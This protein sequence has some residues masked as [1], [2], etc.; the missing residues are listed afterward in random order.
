MIGIAIDAILLMILLKTI[1]DEE[2]NVLTAFAL[3]LIASIAT[4][5]LATALAAIMGVAGI[6]V[7]GIVAAALLGVAI[8][9]LFGVEINRSFAIGGIFFLVH[10][11]FGIGVLLLFPK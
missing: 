2:I 9:A 6:I 8:S 5:V 7:A 10:I 3:A 1:S 4:T 11:A